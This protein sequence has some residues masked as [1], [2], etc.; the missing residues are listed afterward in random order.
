M[1]VLNTSAKA[2]AQ[3]KP[4]VPACCATGTETQTITVDATNSTFAFEIF[5][6][7]GTNIGFIMGGDADPFV[8][9]CGD[10]IRIEEI[11]LLPTDWSSSEGGTTLGT[12]SLDM[13]APEHANWRPCA[14]E[15]FI[16]TV[17]DP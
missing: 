17:T 6:P 5:S 14:T 3:S 13:S 7:I 15:D 4:P 11:S 16:I 8:V 1:A 9:S 12:G 2:L 10:L